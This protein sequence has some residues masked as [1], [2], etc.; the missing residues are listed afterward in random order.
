MNVE[1]EKPSMV[2]MGQSKD[3]LVAEVADEVFFSRSD[4]SDD[5]VENGT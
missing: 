5:K 2:S 3:M 1:F 4:D